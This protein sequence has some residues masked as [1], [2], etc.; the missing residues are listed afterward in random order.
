MAAWL[1]SEQKLRSRFPGNLI[2]LALFLG[3]DWVHTAWVQRN[4]LKVTG[5]GLGCFT[6]RDLTRVF[7]LRPDCSCIRAW[8]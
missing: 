6:V 3:L 1:F 8:G 2:C 7:G 4:A 5:K